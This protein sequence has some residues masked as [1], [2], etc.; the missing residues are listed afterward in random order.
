VKAV[1]RLLT[2]AIGPG[3]NLTGDKFT[4]AIMELRNTTIRELGKSPAQMMLC[5]RLR[6]VLPLP[7]SSL[8]QDAKNII[9]SE[10]RGD[11]LQK[12]Y[13]ESEKRLNEGTQ[14][15]NPIK[16]GTSVRVQNQVGAYPRRWQGTG[17]II[18]VHPHQQYTVKLDGVNRATLRN[19]AFLNPVVS[20]WKEDNTWKLTFDSTSETR[21]RLMKEMA[22]R[23]ELT[24]QKELSHD[25]GEDAGKRPGN[26][27]PGIRPALDRTQ[28]QARSARTEQYD[29]CLTKPPAGPVESGA[30]PPNLQ[31]ARHAL[32]PNNEASQR[33]ALQDMDNQYP[34]RDE[35]EQK[36]PLRRSDRIRAMPPTSYKE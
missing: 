17:V 35:A 16:L 32:H 28:E 29:K 11:F 24:R 23:D 6:N 18:G 7:T 22:A 25:A 30:E 19:Q 1:R 14:I 3:G 9:T 34:P 26:I 20:P 33:P 27:Q 8:T 31:K 10:E 21:D 5:R 4:R 36:Q 15:H 13:A 2:D 12:T